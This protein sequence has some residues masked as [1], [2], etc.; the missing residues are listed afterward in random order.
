M[1]QPKILTEKHCKSMLYTLYSPEMYDFADFKPQL[2]VI[3]THGKDQNWSAIGAGDSSASGVVSGAFIIPKQKIIAG[4]ALIDLMATKPTPRAS[5]V[6]TLGA[7]PRLSF[8]QPTLEEYRYKT[9]SILAHEMFH[10]IQHWRAGD[11]LEDD[12][13]NSAFSKSYTETFYAIRDAVRK[14]HPNWKDELIDAATHAKHPRE[15]EAE[16]FALARLAKY[17]V[18]IQRGEWD[19]SLPIDEMEQY[20]SQWNAR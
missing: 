7:A 20:I 17:R 5:A 12:S 6:V 11:T 2:S 19:N 13:I 4:A 16:R 14:L 18:A 9:L 15:Q 8:S 10:F 1:R 3:F